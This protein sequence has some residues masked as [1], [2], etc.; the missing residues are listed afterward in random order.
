MLKKGGFTLIELLIVVAIIGILASLILASVASARFKARDVGIQASLFEVRN[1][2]ETSYSV[3]GN[4]EAVCD[5][6]NHILSNSGEFKKIG[7]AVRSYNG[8][9]DITCYESSDKQAYAVSSPL[10]YRAG[11]HWCVD[12][13]GI[14]KEESN[15]ITGS[16]CP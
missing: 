8:N 1:A 12:S 2:A 13:V 15:P 4:Y 9:Q 14:S 11:K 6:V 16:I 10:I 7:D 5:D 3:D